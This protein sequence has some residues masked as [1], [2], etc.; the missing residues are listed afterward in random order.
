MLEIDVAPWWS[1]HVTQGLLPL[2]KEASL[3]NFPPVLVASQRELM[4]PTQPSHTPTARDADR[5]PKSSCPG[6]RAERFKWETAC[7]S[8]K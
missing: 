1:S 7:H 3:I 5:R 4:Q 8:H 6:P 2:P